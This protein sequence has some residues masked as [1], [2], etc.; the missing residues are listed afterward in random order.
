[1]S[2]NRDSQH[3]DPKCSKHCVCTV[4]HCLSTTSLSNSLTSGR[5]GHADS[6]FSLAEKYHDFA[7]LV[8]LCHR[9][10][11]YPSHENPNATRIESYIQLFKE[12]FS[13]ELF[14][15]YI[16]HG[17]WFLSSPPLLDPNFV[18]DR[19]SPHH[20]W[21][22]SQKSSLHRC[23]FQAISEHCHFMDTRYRKGKLRVSSCSFT[24]WCSNSNESGGETC[25][26]WSV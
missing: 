12:D 7:N 3:S 11:V 1:M 9:D 15:W 17:L 13:N 2:S 10:T 21:P 19:W 4:F 23:L 26:W 6:A 20:V 16:Q 22:G 8:A 25:Q 5:C 14:H 18:S 24:R